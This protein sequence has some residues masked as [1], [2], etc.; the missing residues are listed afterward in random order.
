MES[1]K[2]VFDY[3]KSYQDLKYNLEFYRTKMEGL[4]AISYSQEQ[5]GTAR[6]DTML[7]CMQKIE[8]IESQM[9]EIEEFIES[10]FSGKTRI[11]IWDR[12]VKDMEYKE[13]AYEIGY[14]TSYVRKFMFS[15][16]DDYLYN[17]K[18]TKKT[19]TSNFI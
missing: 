14:T 1:A 6:Q 5:P 19:K 13:I 4:K 9:K 18:K 7:Y 10:N 17:Y 8:F 12:F 16:I 3:L 15:A 11:A 2:D